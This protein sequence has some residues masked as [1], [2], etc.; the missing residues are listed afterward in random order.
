MFIY[1]QGDVQ[2]DKYAKEINVM[3]KNIVLAQAP[4]KEKTMQNKK[5]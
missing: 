5:E 1:V 4:Q 2:F 3:A